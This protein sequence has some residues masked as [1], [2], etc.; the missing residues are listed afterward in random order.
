MPYLIV[1]TIGTS[2]LTNFAVSC[3]DR[4][5]SLLL[6]ETANLR[7]KELSQEERETIDRIVQDVETR[8]SEA[9]PGEMRRSSAELNGIY[10]YYGQEVNKKQLLARDVHILIATDTYQGKETAHLVERHL[11][12]LGVGMVQ[13]LVPYGLSTRDC[14][15]F[16][17]GINQIVKWCEET[18]PGYARAGYRI[19][20]NLV[21]GF[22]GLQGYMNTLGMFYADEII[23]I[24][25]APSADL[26]RI[27][28]LPVLLDEIPVL[29]QKA[30]LFAMMV[31][32]YLASRE[33][34]EGIPEICLDF[35]DQGSCTL[36]TWGLLIW[37]RNK[38]RVLG[39]HLQQF[40]GLVYEKSFEKDFQAIKDKT[41][42]ADLQAT[43]AKVSLLFRS[44]G[45]EGL[46]SDSGLLYE[47]YAGLKRTGIGHFRLNRNWRVS[48]QAA[49][50]VLR[51]C[52][53]GS[54]DYVNNKP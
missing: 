31:H 53:V 36:S 12:A 26:I 50:S 3:E 37:E 29:R 48:C 33:E 15:S 30:A 47:N 2:L 28:R 8:L 41:R 35:D 19:V 20:F 9:K 42:R 34:V 7:E 39:D 24:F 21:G 14:S 32:G 43:L 5:V 16:S 10:G 27:P 13:V 40:P 54:H 18:L 17:T 25:E 4:S 52:H 49:G 6:R 1:S 22:K 45:L 46:R 11:R 38:E 23:Y 51:L 44:R